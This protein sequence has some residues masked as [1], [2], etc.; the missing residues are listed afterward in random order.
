MRQGRSGISFS[1]SGGDHLSG[2][3]QWSFNVFVPKKRRN[4]EQT[5]IRDVEIRH[6]VSAFVVWKQSGLTGLS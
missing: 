5:E 2:F 4:D 3:Y 1:F 6:V